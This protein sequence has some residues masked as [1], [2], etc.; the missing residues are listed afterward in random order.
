LLELVTN[1]YIRK[2]MSY[3]R[4]GKMSL[5]KKTNCA[6]LIGL[7]WIR[8]IMRKHPNSAQ[9]YACAKSQFYYP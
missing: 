3:I 9:N 1:V 8:L 7:Y 6:E 2:K 4:D 5:V